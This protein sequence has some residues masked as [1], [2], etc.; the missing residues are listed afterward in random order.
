MKAIDLFPSPITIIN[1]Q[2]QPSAI[3]LYKTGG[4]FNQNALKTSPI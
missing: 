3:P 2:N 4:N 1:L